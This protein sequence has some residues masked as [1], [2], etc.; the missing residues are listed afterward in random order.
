MRKRNPLLLNFFISR[1]YDFVYNGQ[2]SLYYSHGLVR[3]LFLLSHLSA[4]DTIWPHNTMVRQLHTER[5]RP[6]SQVRPVTPAYSN[7]MRGTY[8][9]QG[10]EVHLQRD[11]AR[12]L[13]RLDRKVSK[14]D[15][16]E[17]GPPSRPMAARAQAMRYT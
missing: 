16:N 2:P 5:R 11:E 10:R 13:E 6:T 8:L 17:M 9:C 7:T 3:F 4:V 1:I 12:R 15:V 14:E